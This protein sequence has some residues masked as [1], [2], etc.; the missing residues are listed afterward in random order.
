MSFVIKHKVKKAY[1]CLDD[2]GE[3]CWSVS[4]YWAV[5]FDS[6]Q[7]AREFARL[8]G[9]SQYKI[10]EHDYSQVADTSHPKLRKINLKKRS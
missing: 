4:A 3:L 7:K 2:R 5:E 8:E 9:I 6:K 10:V 1:L